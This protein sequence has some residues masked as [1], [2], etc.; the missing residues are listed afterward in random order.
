ML[1]FF[2]NP[3][4]IYDEGVIFE[5]VSISGFSIA[6]CNPQLHNLEISVFGGI[7]CLAFID[8]NSE[9]ETYATKLLHLAI[10]NSEVGL[11]LF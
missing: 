2:L 10:W 3:Y 5:I 7:D 8:R 1:P 9:T 6:H 4:L 11:S